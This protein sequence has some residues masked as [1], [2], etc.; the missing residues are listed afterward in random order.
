[1]LSWAQENYF[2][3]LLAVP[4]ALVL[5]LW[6][7]RKKEILGKYF[8][9]PNSVK[10]NRLYTLTL[11]AI[12]LLLSLSILGPRYGFN[13]IKA[14]A[15][16]ANLIIALDVSQSM[17]TADV[18]P[19]RLEQARR[20]LLDLLPQLKGQRVALLSFAG[21]SFIEV[22]LTADL[23]M[24]E[25][26]LKQLAETASF[27]GG[28]NLELALDTA[29]KA[30]RPR[31]ESRTPAGN[32]LLLSDGEE[33]SGSV[34]SKAE[35]LSKQGIKIYAIGLGTLSGAPVP[36][37]SGFK[38]AADGQIV[39]SK[40]K[41]ET[42]SKLAGLSGAAYLRAS[43]YADPASSLL[44]AGLRENIEHTLHGESIFRSWNEYYQIPLALALLLI[45]FGPWGFACF[46]G[47][48]LLFITVLP[49]TGSAESLEDLGEKARLYYEQGDY[50]KS[51]EFFAQAEA[52]ENDSRV[53]SGLGA[54]S[55]RRGEFSKAREYFLKAAEQAKTAKEKAGSLFNAGNAL[56]KDKEYKKAISLYEQ[57]L[58]LNPEDKE[59]KENLA[60]VKRLLEQEQQQEKNEQSKEEKRKEE[61]SK[62]EQSKKEQSKEEQSQQEQSKD[63]KQENSQQASS[64]KDKE[65]P[66]D[67]QEKGESK[68]DQSNSKQPEAEQGSGK[69]NEDK[70]SGQDSAPA[71]EEPE[72]KKGNKE[73]KENQPQ[74]SE[75]PQTEE[76]QGGRSGGE[77]LTAN[78]LD[79]IQEAGVE[80]QKFRAREGK[81]QASRYPANLGDW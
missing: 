28:S 63:Q 31:A 20:I 46:G 72:E 27:V 58:K 52:L 41:E 66:E 32:I 71:S 68:Q 78:L 49:S 47:L 74:P 48:S 25:Q 59:A 12:V 77:D 30:L 61:Q 9:F 11:S 81:K 2:A 76:K 17:L 55:Y 3:V 73:E 40:L 36:Q 13:E 53:S 1:M 42:L 33:L 39:V 5:G 29:E 51:A 37:G 15:N 34:L 18:S 10:R 4:F 7:A 22:P 6:R 45:I 56:V 38:R 75:K 16:R 80:L 8:K 69:Q 50:E 54:N 43:D 35:Q 65:Q 60:Y 57:S 44:A 64:G 23:G 79:N 19:N 14:Q 24:V 62:K 67:K 26:V 21:A 70:Q